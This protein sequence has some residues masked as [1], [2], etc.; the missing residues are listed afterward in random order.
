MERR[1][2]EGRVRVI[3]REE[4]EIRRK[5]G[6]SENWQNLFTYLVI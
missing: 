3:A 6:R 1:E 4:V 5:R 2:N